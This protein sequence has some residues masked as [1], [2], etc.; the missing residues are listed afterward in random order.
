MAADP[1]LL[2]AVQSVN[3]L[4]EHV[5]KLVEHTGELARQVLADRERLTVL[6]ERFREHGHIGE[7]V[8]VG[9]G[10]CWDGS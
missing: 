2:R 1:D 10:S 4:A 6:E 3:D 7:S 9:L 8:T 5:A